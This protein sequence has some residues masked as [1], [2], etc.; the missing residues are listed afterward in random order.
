M[1]A[2]GDRLAD[3]ERTLLLDHGRGAVMHADHHRGRGAIAGEPLDDECCGSHVL[4]L[5]ADLGARDQAEQAGFVDRVQGLGREYAAINVGSV[6]RGRGRRGLGQ[7]A[8]LE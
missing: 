6:G 7:L 8:A 5:A 4:P 3:R 2:G 1:L